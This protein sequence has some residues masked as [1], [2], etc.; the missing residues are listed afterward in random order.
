MIFKDLIKSHNWL[1][2]KITLLNLYPD[3]KEI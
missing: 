1:S 2:V 3:Q